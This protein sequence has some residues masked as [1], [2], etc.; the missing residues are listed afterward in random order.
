MAR[1]VAPEV[2]EIA[3]SGKES[4]HQLALIVQAGEMEE[5]RERTREFGGSIERELPSGILLISI[6]GDKLNEFISTSAI[7]SIS[8][9][10][11]MRILE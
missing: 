11:R 4:H 7:E 5:I 2:K 10:D 1:Y 6:R 3:Q 9:T 8:T